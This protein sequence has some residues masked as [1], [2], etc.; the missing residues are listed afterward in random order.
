[1]ALY[2]R[3][4]SDVDVATAT[5]A[6]Q[7]GA[8]P[9]LGYAPWYARANY[10]A[11][12]GQDILADTSAG[13]WTLTLPQNPTIYDKVIVRDPKSSWALNNLTFDPSGKKVRGKS[14]NVIGASNDAEVTF[15]YVDDT[16]GWQTYQT[17]SH[18]DAMSILPGPFNADV[19]VSQFFDRLPILPSPTVQG[20]YKD[21][22][23]GLVQ[24]GVW[25][26]LD[27]LWML[28]GA[29]PSIAYTNLIR[30]DLHLKMGWGYIPSF[31]PNTGNMLPSLYLDTDLS[32]LSA[33]G[34][35]YSVNDASVGGWVPHS[36]SGA[37]GIMQ[38]DQTNL[39]FVVAWQYCLNGGFT[40][41]GA[42]PGDAGLYVMQRAPSVNYEVFCNNVS[43]TGLTPFASNGTIVPTNTIGISG[44]PSNPSCCAF[45]GK[46][47]SSGQR[48]ALQARIHT[49][50]TSIRAIS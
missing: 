49:F 44:S 40:Y 48:G 45:I 27:A 13:S 11:T 7:Q 21:L 20:Y 5:V 14:G 26:N 42:A 25:Q 32:Q 34:Y 28:A 33:K 2:T 6:I 16:T 4:L 8:H 19:E 37:I 9:V 18:F 10:T 17:G 39:I 35:N 38:D 15:V 43:L 30:N 24:D 3:P 22:I 29:E 1:M 46:S 31:V 47:L 50:L 36:Y 23:T 12:F 41:A